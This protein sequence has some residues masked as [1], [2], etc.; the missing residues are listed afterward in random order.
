M[1]TRAIKHIRPSL[2]L[3]VIAALLISVI[4]VSA[5]ASPALRTY[6]PVAFPG[7]VDIET[8]NLCAEMS[9]GALDAPHLTMPDGTL[10]PFWGFGDGGV[11]GDCADVSATPS[12]PGPTLVVD[13]GDTVTV[14]L[15]NQID[16][17]ASISENVS[18]HFPGQTLVPDYAG[19]PPCGSAVPLDNCPIGV[20]STS[21]TFTATNPGTYR[22]EAGTD[23]GPGNGESRWQVPMGLHGVLIVRPDP[24]LPNPYATGHAYNDASTA[25]DVE[26][27]LVLSEIDP[28]LNSYPGGPSGFFSFPHPDYPD[29][30]PAYHPT[31]WLINGRAYPDTLLPAVPPPSSQPYTSAISATAGQKVLIRYVN[32][33]LLHHTMQL[34]GLHQRVLAKDSDLLP[35]PFDAIAETMPSGSTADMIVSIPALAAACTT[36]PLYNRQ[37][38]LTNGTPASVPHAPGGMMTFLEVSPCGPPANT[39][40]VV[41]ITSPADLST[42]TFGDSVTFTGTALDAEDGDIS[43]SLSWN[44]N[45]DGVIGSGGSFSTTTLT[46]GTHTITASVTDSGAL[47]GSASITITINPAGNTPPVVTITAPADLST[48]TVGDSVTFT[49]TAIDTEDGDISASLSWSSDVDGVIGSGGSFSTTTLSVGTHIITA[50]VTDSGALPGSA[51]ITITV[52]PPA[53]M[54]IGAMANASVNSPPASLLFWTAR[55]TI[56]IHD[57]SHTPVGAGITVTGAWTGPGTFIETGGLTCITDGSGLCTVARI[58]GEF[59]AP[60]A[61]FTVSGVSGGPLTYTPG[62][63]D[64]GPGLT[65]PNPPGF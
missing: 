47:P 9:T 8:F 63:N 3:L 45:L 10:I 29:T 38:H 16:D 28:A 32:A 20:P 51:F 19:A 40:P 1:L 59:T 35:A 64:A 27:T 30:T 41:T 55:V 61:T 52:S 37:L 44:S 58:R 49:G 21:Y 26:A 62:D 6:K 33:G 36:Y 13:Q 34:L 56:T 11:T 31:Y 43:L 17:G 14:N 25:Y 39:P 22:Y 23:T 54:H 48:F 2:A 15:Y 65:V 24:T 42:F 50:S 60:T 53:T 57:A 46:V 7:V 18:I 12:L 4:P 5:G